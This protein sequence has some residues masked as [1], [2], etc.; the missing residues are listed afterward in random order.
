MLNEYLEKVEFDT[1]NPEA[2][3]ACVLVLDVSGSMHGEPLKQLNNG[4]QAFEQAL[5]EDGL[6]A[7]RVEIAVVTFGNGVNVEKDF[8]SAGHFE[9]PQ[10]SASGLTPM[11]E[12]MN[13]SLDMIRQRKDTY[14]QNGVAY[15]RPWIFLITDG[16]PT[17]EW[18]SAAQ[19]VQQAEARKSVAFFCVGVQNADMS[20]LSKITSRHP[21]K[22]KGLHF[23]EMF[24]WLSQ[25]LTSVSH[26]Q[27]GEQVPLTSPAGWAEV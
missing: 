26:S 20:T 15:Y 22:L 7:M 13:L 23:R 14:K 18:Q 6:A 3:C 2:R 25:S 9:A 1:S 16:V 19:R 17:D 24:V 21:V 11:G 4:V 8:V 10:L 5:K 27:V 12:A